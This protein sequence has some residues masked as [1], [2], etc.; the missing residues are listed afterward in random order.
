MRHRKAYKRLGRKTAH[1][2]AMVSALLCGLIQDKRITTTLPKAKVTRQAAEK[3]VTLARKGTLAARRLAVARLR[4]TACVRELFDTIVPRLASRQGGYTRIVKIGHR[5][6]DAA[7]LAIVEW[8]D[9]A[10]EVQPAV[11]VA[12]TKSE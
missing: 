2:E 6:G 1:R 12:T 4:R 8:V 10:L 11:E 5:G 9:I 7:D 3:M